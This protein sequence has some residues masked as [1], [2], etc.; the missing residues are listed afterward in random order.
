MKLCTSTA[1]RPA[2]KRHA[3]TGSNHFP[4]DAEPADDDGRSET[5]L[6]A[7]PPDLDGIDT[8]FAATIDA[9][10]LRQR[11]PLQLPLTAQVGLDLG[12]NVQH[13]EER[14]PKGCGRVW[15]G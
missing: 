10:R 1:G 3:I 6:V 4:P 7:Q 15:F 11:D 5:I 13:V 2:V 8:G 9:T 12:K 14:Q